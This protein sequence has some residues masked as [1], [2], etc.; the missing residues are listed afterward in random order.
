MENSDWVAAKNM[1]WFFFLK[2]ETRWKLNNWKIND[3]N[4][5]NVEHAHSVQTAH[6]IPTI[7]T[8]FSSTY[9]HGKNMTTKVIHLRQVPQKMALMFGHGDRECC[10]YII[11]CFKTS[12]CCLNEGSGLVLLLI[13]DVKKYFFFQTALTQWKIFAGDQFLFFLH[14]DV[15]FENVVCSGNW[16]QNYFF[17]EQN[18]KSLSL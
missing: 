3:I 14:A 8:L 1:N 18:L 6:S 9:R 12:D 2:K 16:I 5:N 10:I 4:I 15:E 7:C 11:F 13:V 17:F